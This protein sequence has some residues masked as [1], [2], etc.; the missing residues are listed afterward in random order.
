MLKKIIYE[1][2]YAF[3]LVFSFFLHIQLRTPLGG[4]FLFLILLVFWIY[5]FSNHKLILTS[6][7]NKRVSIP[8]FLLVFW[9]VISTVWSVEPL[10]ALYRVSYQ[11]I[12]LLSLL[13]ISL[14]VSLARL[15]EV[16]FKFCVLVLIVDILVVLL[17]PSIG[18]MGGVSGLHYHKNSF[19]A[20]LAVISVVMAFS[21][22]TNIRWQLFSLIISFICFLI[23]AKTAFFASFLSIFLT[24]FF[25]QLLKKKAGISL[26][27]LIYYFLTPIVIVAM[28]VATIYLPQIFNWLSINIPEDFMTGRGGIWN[29]ALSFVTDIYIGTGFGSFW[30]LSESSSNVNIFADSASLLWMLKIEQG[31]NGYLDTFV[32]VGWIGLF[33]LVMVMV[34][35]ARTIIVCALNNYF[36]PMA[37]FI[38]IL[39]FNFSE[40]S[41]L[42]Y[43]S[44]LWV[45]FI[46]F[47][48]RKYTSECFSK[49]NLL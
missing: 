18:I 5:L 23:G 15:D 14:T 47:C 46:I 20:I 16:L 43:F 41:Y 49:R 11:I 40:T 10:T 35:S 30:Q 8:V 27:S 13:I 32:S 38:L 44:P 19:G 29:F 26:A 6:I 31:H 33:L 34:G 48:C 9:C 17:I 37:L 45:V 42:N 39:I 24:V 22:S 1:K 21:K 7:K 3:I 25:Q 28:I 12:L 4:A 2:F 36:L